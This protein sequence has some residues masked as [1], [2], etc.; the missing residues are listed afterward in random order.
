M[1]VNLNSE[2]E[3]K[4][5]IKLMEEGCTDYLLPKSLRLVHEVDDKTFRTEC[6]LQLFV[7]KDGK[8]VFVR[9]V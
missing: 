2:K 1:D 8:P 7:D 5:I 9:R 6:T 3:T 4:Y